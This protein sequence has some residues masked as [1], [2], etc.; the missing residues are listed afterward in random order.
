LYFFLD[1]SFDFLFIAYPK[2]TYWIPC[3]SPRQGRV[4]PY[5]YW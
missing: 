4:T 5:S 2:R 1:S 3:Q